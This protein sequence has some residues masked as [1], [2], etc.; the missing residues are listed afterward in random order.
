MVKSLVC[1]TDGFMSENNEQFCTKGNTY[2]VVEYHAYI[3]I[4]DNQGER[5]SFTPSGAL[6]WFDMIEEDE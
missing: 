1:H 5:H 4:K 6:K 2:E 3:V